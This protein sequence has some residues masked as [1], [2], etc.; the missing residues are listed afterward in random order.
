MLGLLAGPRNVTMMLGNCVL[1]ARSETMPV[2]YQ[3]KVTL[4]HSNP[5]VWRRILVPEGSLD[6]LHKWVQTAMGWENAHLHRFDIQRKHYGDPEMLDDGFGETRVIDSLGVQLADLFDRP[7]PAKRFTYEYDFGDGWMHELEFEG[8]VDPPRGKKPPCCLEGER[9]CPPEDC[10]GVWGYA[11]LL[12]VLAD[13][14]HEE[15]EQYA[16][17]FPNGIDVEVFRTNEATKAMRQGL[18]RWGD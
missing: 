9:A 11:H 1:H 4:I 10:G 17:W 14:N 2:A 18:P 7:R 16:E 5:P 12:D 15:Y 13:P 8:I 6:D 3:F